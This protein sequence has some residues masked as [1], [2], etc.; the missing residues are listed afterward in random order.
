MGDGEREC[1]ASSKRWIVVWAE[2]DNERE[3]A[4]EEEGPG[5]RACV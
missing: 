2:P 3:K 1:A 5:L 4:T